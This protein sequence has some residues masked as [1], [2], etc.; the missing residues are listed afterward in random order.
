ML[1]SREPI[2]D[3][4]WRK[5]LLDNNSTYF[6]NTKTKQSHWTAPPELEQLLGELNKKAESEPAV[7]EKRKEVEEDADEGSEKRLKAED[8]YGSILCHGYLFACTVLQRCL[9]RKRQKKK[10]KK[11]RQKKSNKLRSTKKI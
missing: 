5:V 4:T 6:F 10:K 3:G 7:G 2:G 1:I 11:G 9:R 8:G